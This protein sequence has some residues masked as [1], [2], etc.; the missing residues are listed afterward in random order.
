MDFH[1]AGDALDRIHRRQR[2]FLHVVFPGLGSETLVRIDPGNHEPRDALIDAPLD[3][4][5]VGLEIENV[6]LVDPR[7]HDQEWRAQHA[8]RHG[9]ILD[10][11]HQVVLED[12]LAGRGRHVDA[13]FE[14]GR[15]R[16]A[17]PKRAV[18]GLDILRQHL[19]AAHEIVAVRAQGLAQHLRIGEDEV[20]RSERVGELLD[21]K[22]GLLAG[23][24][25]E[26]LGVAHQIVRPLRRQQVKLQ[27]EVEELVRFPFGI[28]K[29][30]VARRRCGDGRNLFAGEAPYRAAPQVEIGLADPGLN[31]VGAI[32][33]R[34]PVFGDGAQCLDEFGEFARRLVRYFA[35]GSRLQIGCKRLAAFL[36]RFGDVHGESFGVEFRRVLGFCGDVRHGA[37]LQLHFKFVIA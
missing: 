3:E 33:V 5:F 27:N 1:F 28:G 19:H 20:G 11:L 10:Q 35:V 13:D 26:A 17:D 23:M 14:I 30:L 18:P 6:E 24:R 21:V 32:G 2:P 34:Q 22:G 37:R 8:F 4:G 16:L 7:R 9:C 36:H 25:V 15:I 12:H 29:P 31:V